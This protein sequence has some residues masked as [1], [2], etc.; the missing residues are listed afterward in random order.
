MAI[1]AGY[2]PSRLSPYTRLL[3]LTRIPQLTPSA[4]GTRPGTPGAGV[5]VSEET[6]LRQLTVLIADARLMERKAGELFSE[7][8][9][10]RLPGESEAGAA[11]QSS[12][13]FPD[14]PCAAH[15]LSP[16]LKTS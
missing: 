12:F 1:A 13:V 10:A 14:L 11:G 4:G 8:I 15:L 2:V 16:L 6:T 5:D 3:T 7:R 9:Q